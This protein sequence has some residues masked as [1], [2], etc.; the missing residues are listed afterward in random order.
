M[1]KPTLARAR[2]YS[3][4]DCLQPSAV[5]VSC[6]ACGRAPRGGAGCVPYACSVRGV[7]VAPSGRRVGRVRAFP[8]GRPS[9][10]G[11]MGALL[12]SWSGRE[13]LAL[14]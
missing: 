10:V 12:R 11:E 13:S 6:M 9:A 1:L 3:A 4:A 14:T 2:L 7:V 5:S 8:P